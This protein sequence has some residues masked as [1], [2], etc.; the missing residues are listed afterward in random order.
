VNVGT[1]VIVL[2]MDRRAESAVA[3][4]LIK[5]AHLN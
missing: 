3:S 2:P 5:T 4:G 1:K